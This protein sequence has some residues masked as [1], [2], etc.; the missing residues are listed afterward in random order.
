MTWLS[1]WQTRS[2]I[3]EFHRRNG[4]RFGNYMR[5]P[6]FLELNSNAATQIVLNVLIVM[7]SL[8]MELSR[9]ESS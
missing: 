2:G 4:N 7:L 8:R 1:G 3:S 5:A 6:S 9:A